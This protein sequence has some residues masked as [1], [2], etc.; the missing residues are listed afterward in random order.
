MSQKIHGSFTKK[1]EEEKIME[2]WKICRNEKIE[3]MFSLFVVT[4]IM[5]HSGGG[6]LAFMIYGPYRRFVK[7]VKKNRIICIAKSA[8][9]LKNI[10]N[11]IWYKPW[12]WRCIQTLGDESML[13]AYGLTNDGVHGCASAILKALKRG[14]NVIPSYYIKF[15]DISV[16]QAIKDTLTAMSIY[17]SVLGGYFW[18]I[19]INLS[20][21]NSGED[22]RANM[23]S[24]LR[25]IGAI[26]KKYPRLVII[27]KVG[28]VHPYS[29]IRQL[30]AIGIDIIHAINTIPFNKLSA[31]KISPLQKIGGGGVSGGYIHDPALRYCSGAR[32]NTDLKFI[33]AGGIRR[34]EHARNFINIG[35]DY[36]GIC[37]HVR[38]NAKEALKT[39]R[40]F[41]IRRG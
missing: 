28:V 31:T 6:F 15:K 39:I 8:T 7:Y 23:K 4:S 24:A 10:G 21:P 33:M 34:P 41:P 22:L 18:A 19:E 16:E 1:Y 36:L 38:I 13:N 35:A 9:L 26:R 5:G 25:C 27:V 30:E 40:S 29:F 14:F 3:T 11:F 12:T 17:R 20:C 2:N 37:T 32:E